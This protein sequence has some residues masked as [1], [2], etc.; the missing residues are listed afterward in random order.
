MEQL[1]RVY[2]HTKD[3]ESVREY[4]VTA[5]NETEATERAIRHI[6]ESNL[7][8]SGRSQA[9]AQALTSVLAVTPTSKPHCL[10]IHS[11]P[12]AAMRQMVNRE[13]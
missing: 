10:M 9:D 7:G 12:A 2:L 11:F 3:D 13:R 5:P 8:K 4:I 1:Y 6:K